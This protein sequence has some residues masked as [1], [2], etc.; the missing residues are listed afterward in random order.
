MAEDDVE[1]FPVLASFVAL[2]VSVL[3]SL[4]VV[5]ATH[6]GGARHQSQSRRS[7]EVIGGPSAAERNDCSESKVTTPNDTES[8]ESKVRKARANTS[9]SMK[10][11]ETLV[12][13]SWRDICCS[14]PVK[15]QQPR[16]EELSTD[17]VVT[18]HNSYGEVVAGELTAIMGRR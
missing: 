10:C 16:K 17:S 4:W 9:P 5:I 18:L 13:L 6:S 8:G 2:A 14:Y 1:L 3:F 7:E 15:K 12:M 11:R